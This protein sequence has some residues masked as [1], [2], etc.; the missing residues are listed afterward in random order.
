MAFL[1]VL[2]GILVF[3][4]LVLCSEMS[5]YLEQHLYGSI[6]DDLGQSESGP[7][8]CPPWKYHKPNESKCVCRHETHGIVECWEN[9][10]TVLLLSC[11]CI[12]YSDS[13]DNVVM[14]ACPFLCTN[15]FYTKVYA[16]TNLTTL[17][18]RDIHQNRQGQLCGQCKDN[19]SPSP[20]SY[21]LKCA[22]CSHY[23]Y[24]WLRYVVIAYAP[25]TVFF[26]LV[27]IFR[28][29]ALSA[30]MNTFIFFCQMI[31]C[32]EVANESLKHICVLLW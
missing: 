15:N 4:H 13:G 14:G 8:Q 10:S 1:R 31:S 27:I 7:Y 12:S 32:P 5:D 17:C 21:Q 16:D 28:L 19:H 26:F 20:Y 24:N 6:S 23:K 11:H 25:L 29:N 2:S 3:S 30:S 22:H 18:D 9:S